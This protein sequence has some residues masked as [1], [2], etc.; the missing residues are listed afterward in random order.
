MEEYWYNVEAGPEGKSFISHLLL[1]DP[2]G[3]GGLSLLLY[4]GSLRVADR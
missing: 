3:L 2:D 1:I 4:E